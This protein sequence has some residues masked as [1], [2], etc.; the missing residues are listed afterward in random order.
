LRER[1]I[2]IRDRRH[3]VPG[4]VRIT[5]GT[6][7]Q[8]ELALTLLEEIWKRLSNPTSTG[9]QGGSQ[10]RPWIAFDMDGVLVDV[11]KSYRATIIQTV[12]KLSGHIFTPE[13]VQALKNEGGYNNDWDLCQELL[14]RRRVSV[15][16]E[17][18]V[19]VFNSIYLGD[20][21]N[22]LIQREQW[23]LDAELLKTLRE[24]Y[25]LAIFTGRPRADA[26]YV[27]Q[28]F[29][30]SEAFEQV[31]AMEDVQQ[32]KPAPE[33]LQKLCSTCA[34]APL[35]AYVGDTVDDA[36]C[37]RAAGIPFIGVLPSDHLSRAELKTLFQGLG[38]TAIVENVGEAAELLLSEMKA[39]VEVGP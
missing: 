10:A 20:K 38:S 17:E 4:A 26:E 37:A 31:V 14:R 27:L 5:C 21:W 8:T 15:P 34:P 7:A 2:L 32:G 11:R 13:D 16:Y 3:D 23:L 24:H 18:I 36:R 35:V 28:R 33:G 19:R 25:R 29:G 6:V 12:Q 39:P 30:L 9:T 22:G 1:D